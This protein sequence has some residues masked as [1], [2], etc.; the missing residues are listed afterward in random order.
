MVRG[1]LLRCIEKNGDGACGV[2]EVVS[3]S[4]RPPLVGTSIPSFVA[5]DFVVSGK[6]IQE[7]SMSSMKKGA[8]LILTTIDSLLKG[9]E[10]GGE[11]GGGGGEGG[12]N[13][14]M[15]KE[16]DMEVE[17]DGEEGGEVPM[18]HVATTHGIGL[19]RISVVQDIM[20]EDGNSYFDQRRL[21]RNDFRGQTRTIRV[22]LPPD[23]YSKDIKSG[24]SNYSFRHVLLGHDDVRTTYHLVRR[25]GIMALN[26]SSKIGGGVPPLPAWLRETIVQG[27]LMPTEM[28]ISTDRDSKYDLSK[29]F[30]SLKQVQT[31]L[32]FVKS[33]KSG[34][35]GGG[36]GSDSGSGGSGI[37]YEDEDDEKEVTNNDQK[38]FQTRFLLP[39]RRVE[40]YYSDVQ[41][42]VNG[43]GGGSMSSNNNNYNKTYNLP[44]L[45]SEQVH[46]VLSCLTSKDGLT[47]LRGGPGSGKSEAVAHLVAAL[48]RHPDERV[49]LLSPTV[50]SVDRLLSKLE[51]GHNLK[52]RHL[53]RIGGS[54]HGYGNFGPY[55]RREHCQRRQRQILSRVSILSE[56]LGVTEHGVQF[57]CE[58]A[59]H[60]YSV[61]VHSRINI[62]LTKLEMNGGAINPFEKYFQQIQRG[63]RGSGSGSGVSSSERIIQQ[64][65]QMTEMFDELRDYSPFEWMP[66][67]RH[68]I[69][70]LETTLSK[71]V[72]ASIDD[73]VRTL[74]KYDDDK[75]VDGNSS[76][77]P[78]F[79]TIVVDGAS[80]VSEAALAVILA[81]N[82]NKTRRIVLTGDLNTSTVVPSSFSRATSDALYVGAKM[83]TN[84]FQRLTRAAFVLGG[85]GSGS[86]GGGGSSGGNA[87]TLSTHHRSRP[88]V[89]DLYKWRYNSTTMT[90]TSNSGGI[91]QKKK[92]LANTGLRYVSQFINVNEGN[93]LS[94]PLGGYQNLE[95][96][97]YVVSMYQYLRLLGHPGRSIV[98][99]TT[100]E[101][102]SNL[103]KDIM[104][105]RCVDS[106]HFGK[107]NDVT[108]SLY[109][110]IYIYFI[111]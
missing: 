80:H 67:A 28:S 76:S 46:F 40:V 18:Q 53:L 30:R 58:T 88:G 85:G 33:K 36:N 32:E 16:N 24:I 111:S 42:N 59:G 106:P 93:E 43:G 45:D 17:E 78:S 37:T 108:V 66:F 65:D 27:R 60:F 90:M 92:Y 110:N 41:N 74:Y 73:M 8:V 69:S 11:G 7:L 26:V 64:M 82:R 86:G 35:G 4:A 15:E 84:L 62:F 38:K 52:P 44:D 105:L 57:T 5:L 102:Q 81:Y 101:E 21:D 71:V 47:I 68:Q 3:L 97:E 51:R 95:E 23:Q 89:L 22:H 72:G 91:Q 104:N 25:L 20:D 87:H 34:G 98:I 96:A 14:D 19:T 6:E 54:G 55:G 13:G 75:D 70:Y 63:S 50:G 103:I 39:S 109:L 49:L 1:E 31:Y 99:L 107:P 10:E 79:T 9:G 83:N 61:H 48:S 56:S 12:E 77:G 100:Y 29:T 94:C 2:S